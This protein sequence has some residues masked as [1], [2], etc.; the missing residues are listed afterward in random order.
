MRKLLAFGAGVAL[1]L[2]VTTGVSA[3]TVDKKTLSFEAAMKVAAA[4]GAAARARGIGVVIAVVDAGGHLILLHRLDD[5]Q[6]ASVNV[7]MGKARTAAIYRRP[8]KDFEDQIRAGR[9][10]ALALADSTPL[11]GGVPIRLDGKVI[12]AI[13]VSG[14][15]PQVDEAIAIVGAN[16]FK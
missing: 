16:A 5:T 4:A 10:A 6:V 12:G 1:S 13:G 9:V 2:S 11:Q 8:S 3:Q 15:T 14:D 7:G